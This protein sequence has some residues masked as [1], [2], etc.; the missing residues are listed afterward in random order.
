MLDEGRKEELKKNRRERP[1]IAQTDTEIRLVMAINVHSIS[2]IHS[3][4][5]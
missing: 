4:S 2:D 3:E 1:E 5:A